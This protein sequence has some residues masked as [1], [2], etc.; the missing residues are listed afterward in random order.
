MSMAKKTPHHLERRLGLFQ[1]TLAGV[2]TIVGAGIFVLIGI[3]VKKFV[4]SD[5]VVIFLLLPFWLVFYLLTA[6][7]FLNEE[8]DIILSK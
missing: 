5:A 3:V 8:K 2:G 7:K 4:Y 6:Y 1:T